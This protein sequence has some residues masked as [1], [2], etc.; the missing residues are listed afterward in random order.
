MV[1]DYFCVC[2]RVESQ[3]PESV[4]GD[5]AE[6]ASPAARGFGE[7]LAVYWFPLVSAYFLRLV[8]QCSHRSY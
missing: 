1:K 6:V 3:Q 4:G 2:D 5:D 7:V 8:H